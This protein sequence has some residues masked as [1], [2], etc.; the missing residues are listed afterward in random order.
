MEFGLFV[1]VLDVNFPAIPPLAVWKNGDAKQL[2]NFIW[3]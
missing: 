3:I 1:F 2:R